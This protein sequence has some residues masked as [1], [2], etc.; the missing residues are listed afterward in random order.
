MSSTTPKTLRL[1]REEI[2]Y[3]KARREEV[4]I[5]LRLQ[6]YDRQEAFFDSLSNNQDAIKAVIVHH[7][8]LSSTNQCQ[9]ADVED[10]LH[11]SFNV[12]IPVTIKDWKTRTQPGTRVLLRLPLPY[13][14]GEDVCPGNS[15]EK[16]RCEAGTYA[17][18]QENCPD[19]PIPRLYGFATSDGDTV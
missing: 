19:I 12:C 1:L 13:K 9:I 16:I 17:W 5:L 2:T 3:S 10:W 15:D 14:L 4:D 7:L 18:L 11:G 6:H 8:G